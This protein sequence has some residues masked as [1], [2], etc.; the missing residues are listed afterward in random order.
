MGACQDFH[1]LRL[2]AAFTPCSTISGTRSMKKNSYVSLAVLALALAA[3]GG[4]GG[5]G[6]DPS[7]Y[8][9][10]TAGPGSTVASAELAVSQGTIRYAQYQTTS[11]T[12]YDKSWALPSISATVNFNSSTRQGSIQFPVAGASEL[13][14]TS[15]AYATA[16]WTG[17]FPSGAYRFN[18]NILVGCGA[19][20]SA[21]IDSTQVFVSSSLERIRDGAVDDLN[22]TTYDIVNCPLLQQSKVETL[23]INADGSVYLSLTNSTIPK[24]QAFDM[25]NPEKYPGALFTNASP[26]D[27]YYAG[28][29]FRYDADGV[30]RHAIVIQTST[31]LYNAGAPAL[32][33]GG[34]PY[35]YL[36]AIQR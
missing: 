14:S 22:G 4:G 33:N 3:C 8:K 28:H 23:K 29:A 2:R 30:T 11:T 24:N 35:H 9:A 6:S 1:A 21:A 18:G 27:G 34:S 10:T 32:S 36:L 31:R 25:F 16:S 15:D 13:I 12:M 7:A 20:T 26:G 17:P 5:G 19:P